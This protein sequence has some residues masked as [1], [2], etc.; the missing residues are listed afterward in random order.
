MFGRPTMLLMN[1]INGRDCRTKVWKEGGL[2]FGEGRWYFDKY[3]FE[4]REVT[5]EEFSRGVRRVNVEEF[6]ENIILK[7]SQ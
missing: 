2:L 4:Q 6:L 3:A 7:N 5:A 1:Y